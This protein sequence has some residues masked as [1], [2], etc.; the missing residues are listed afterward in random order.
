MYVADIGPATV[1]AW[2]AKVSE[3]ASASAR[4]RPAHPPGHPA[5]RWALAEGHQVAATG[6]LSPRV[7]ALWEAAGKPSG[8]PAT[9]I[10]TDAGRTTAAQAY[11][12]LRTLLGA[13]LAD[14]AITEN[15]CRLRGAGAV[16]HRE[17]A[18]ATLEEINRLAEN[19]PAR[20]SA[21]VRVA[22]WSGLR[23]G[24]LF[25][26]SRQHISPDGL[27]IRVDRALENTP[28]RAL[29]FG[30]PKSAASYRTIHLPSTVAQELS[31]HMTEFAG[32]GPDALVFGLPDGSPLPNVQLSRIFRR[33]RRAI[34]RDDLTWHDLRH[35]GATLAYAAGASIPDVQRRLGH[36]T[37]RAAQ[38][39]AHSAADADRLLAQRLENLSYAE[40]K[41]Q[42]L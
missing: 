23:Y 21:A 38:V 22:A 34:G 16:V 31:K 7:L 18:T 5:R 8:R 2:F 28:G 32:E 40:R 25:A 37:I 20:F 24:E 19:M 6:R 41:D 36:S 33:A 12:L 13:A 1:R 4:R 14:G 11:R 29:R 27:S 17:R 42:P 26:L 10:S 3:E 35:T 15:P 30:P 9:E 39:Y